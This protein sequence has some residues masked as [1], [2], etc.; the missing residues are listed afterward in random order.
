MLQMDSN[1]HLGKNIIKEDPHE[2][3]SNGKMFLDFM[4]RMPHLT[5]VNTL[6]LCE[7]SI[8]RMRK[9]SRGLEESILDF[10]VVCQQILPFI[11]KMTIDDKRENALTN[12]AKLK[13]LVE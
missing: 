2:Q 8:T 11:T 12:I 6:E 10:F 5:I 9:S 3:N 7:G 4:E 1:A 13:I